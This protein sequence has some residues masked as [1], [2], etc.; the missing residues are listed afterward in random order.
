MDKFKLKKKLLYIYLSHQ[1]KGNTQKELH[2]IVLNGQFQELDKRTE[3]DIKSFWRHFKNGKSPNLKW[4][5]VFNLFEEDKQ[6]LKYYIPNDFYYQYVDTLFADVEK[7]HVIDDKNMYDLYFS[8]ANMPKTRFRKINGVYEDENYN[9]ISIDEVLDR[10]QGHMVIKKSVLSDSGK[11]VFF[12]D[13]DKT[14]RRMLINLLESLDN[15][16]IQEKINQHALLSNIHPDSINTIRIVSLLFNGEVRILSSFLRM[17]T[18]GSVIDAAHAGGIVCGIDDKGVLSDFALDM[19][20]NKLYK[21]PQGFIF[22]GQ[23]ISGFDGCKYIVKQYA[24]RF[25]Y[26]SKLIAW[27]FAIDETGL[28][29]LIEANFHYG[30]TINIHQIFSGPIFGDITEDVLQYVFENHPLLCK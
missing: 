8:G 22:K 1:R 23:S 24:P 17:G 16:I 20:L 21:H 26:T 30:G 3:E 14:D 13:E 19:K 2:N 9:L 28:P 5:E 18:N 27:D 10:C 4:F 6:R 25:A 12:W 7:S 11:G 29:V 15:L